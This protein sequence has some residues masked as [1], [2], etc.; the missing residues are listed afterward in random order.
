MLLL[1]VTTTTL[2]HC[3][4]IHAT[5]LDVTCTLHIIYHHQR[6]L[7]CSI[8]TYCDHQR[9]LLRHHR[10]HHFQTDEIVTE[11]SRKVPCFDGPPEKAPSG[12]YSPPWSSLDSLSCHNYHRH[13][14]TTE[15]SQQ[16]ILPWRCLHL[17]PDSVHLLGEV[18]GP[19]W[20][21]HLLR[22]HRLCHA[23]SLPGETQYFYNSGVQIIPSMTPRMRISSFQIMIIP[24]SAWPWRDGSTSSTGSVIKKS[25]R[26]PP[27]RIL[28]HI[29][30]WSDWRRLGKLLQLDLFC[31]SHCN[32]F[33]LHAQ[34]RPWRSQRVSDHW[35]RLYQSGQ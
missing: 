10:H 18:G 29:C 14:K 24:S 6:K 30:N 1:I 33:I 20:R 9:H 3:C 27:I 35:Q 25:G 19:Q 4:S 7:D 28:L 23:H 15:H 16:A 26:L 12:F 11:G 21:H 2:D 31:P 8:G 34:P 13:R 17:R 32:R 22:Q 5:Q